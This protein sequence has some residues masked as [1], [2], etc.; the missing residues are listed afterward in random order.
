MKRIVK[1]V[2]QSNARY[3]PDWLADTPWAVEALLR[4]LQGPPVRRV[5]FVDG[6]KVP[7]GISHQKKRKDLK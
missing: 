6:A 2:D 4:R 3:A 5:L 1:K 7:F